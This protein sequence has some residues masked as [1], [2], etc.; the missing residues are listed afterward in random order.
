MNWKILKKKE[1]ID[2]LIEQSNIKPCL[3]FKHSISCPISSMAKNRLGSNWDL[4]NEDVD[5]YFL[6]LINYRSTSNR[7]AEVFQIK[8]ESPQALLI[9]E[10]VCVYNSS[11]LD[12]TAVDI[13]QQM[14]LT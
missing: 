9:K 14:A 2:L 5:I 6:D 8:H 10:G 4:S 3:I 11:H 7:I 1:D 13:K 12:I